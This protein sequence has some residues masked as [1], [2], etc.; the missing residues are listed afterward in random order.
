[1]GETGVTIN[2]LFKSLNKIFM[3]FTSTVDHPY[4]NDSNNLSPQQRRSSRSPT[5]GVNSPSRQSK[6][7]QHPAHHSQQ[8]SQSSENKYSRDGDKYKH[9]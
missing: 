2:Y 7:P 9:R 3:S 6:S 4:P 5:P 1:M 8:L